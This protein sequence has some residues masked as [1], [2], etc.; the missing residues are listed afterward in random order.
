MKIQELK[1]YFLE[2]AN[3][4]KRYEAIETLSQKLTK[5]KELFESIKGI[6]AECN[7]FENLKKNS[8]ICSFSIHVLV[9]S[10]RPEGMYILIQHIKSFD[11]FMPPTYVE[12]LAKVLSFF[13]KIIIGPAIE[14]TQYP[15][16]TPQNAI[17]VQTLCNLFLEGMLGEEHLPYIVKL[18]QEYDENPYSSQYLIDLIKSTK[19]FKEFVKKQKN[20]NLE[21][22]EDIQLDSILIEK[23]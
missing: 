5:D 1:L 22:E 2:V 10:Q 8:T 16:G 20:Q 7:N 18:I 9:Q 21:L 11:S 15:I 23:T 14:L 12:F 6:L 17:G 13:G 4:F 3:S 19:E